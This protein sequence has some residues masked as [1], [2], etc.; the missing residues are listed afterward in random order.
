[1]KSSELAK[2]AGVS[3]RT[4]RHYHAI[5]LLPEPPRQSNGYRDYS[6]QDLAQLLRIKRLSSL[7]FSL[8]RVSE[9]LNEMDAGLS[10]EAGTSADN[11]LDLL[12]KELALQIE[13]LEEQRRTIRLLKQ[14]RLDPDLP[15]RFA[16]TIKPLMGYANAATNV[17]TSDR[18]AL[19]VAG[20]LIPEN[21]LVELESISEALHDNEL[22]D[23]LYAIQNRHDT[24]D[25][26][27]SQ[28]ERDQLVS[29][30]LALFDPI[31]TCFESENWEQEGSSDL[32]IIIDE[33]IREGLNSAQQDVANRIESALEERILARRHQ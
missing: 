22:L 8:E 23:A 14:E 29:D 25:P 16:R 10:A 18:A 21:Y 13:Q 31:I 33:L 2:L 7:G 3:V 28:K 15:I 11:A 24:L 6:V 17:A 30:S 9:V 5:G 27:A 19:L 32:E 1:M 20:H 12:D 26:E 4:L